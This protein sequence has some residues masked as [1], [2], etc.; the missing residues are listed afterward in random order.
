MLELA[1]AHWPNANERTEHVDTNINRF[2]A[3]LHVY[4]NEYKPPANRI[5]FKL[6]QSVP[7]HRLRSLTTWFCLFTKQMPGTIVEY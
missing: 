3:L 5:T 4:E 7:L 2:S 6:Q 1:I